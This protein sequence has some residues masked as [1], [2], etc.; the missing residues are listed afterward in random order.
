[1]NPIRIAIMTIAAA[2]A[3]AFAYTVFA[4]SPSKVVATPTQT[5]VAVLSAPATVVQ[6]PVIDSAAQAQ[7][8]IQYLD[9]PAPRQN[10][11]QEPQENEDRNGENH[12]LE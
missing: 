7:P 3:S 9:V 11:Y 5:Q 12:D 4:P 10:V 6:A 2:S 1:M 8:E